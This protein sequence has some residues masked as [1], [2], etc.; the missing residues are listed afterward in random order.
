VRL[1]FA[2][3]VCSLAFACG[4]PADTG[5]A[6]TAAKVQHRVGQL[7]P[8]DMY[9]IALAA[10]TNGAGGA[11]IP[12]ISIFNTAASACRLRVNL[13]FSVREG[14][15]KILPIRGNPDRIT[16]K[17]RGLG[18]AQ[19][20]WVSWSWSNWCGRAKPPFIYEWRIGQIAVRLFE[21]VS[22][23][24]DQGTSTLTLLFACP[25]PENALLIGPR[26]RKT[27]RFACRG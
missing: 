18:R 4:F 17:A 15:G 23:R 5:G 14:S 21:P 1:A 24:C 13:T 6:A 12:S 10:A 11:L 2:L 9:S 7:N 20:A 26:L 25:Q 27:A 19:R 3:G 8:C 22:P 16:L